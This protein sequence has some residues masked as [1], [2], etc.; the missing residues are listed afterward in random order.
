MVRGFPGSED[1]EGLVTTTD[2]DACSESPTRVAVITT[3]LLLATSGAVNSPLGEMVPALADQVTAVFGLP[4]IVAVNCSCSRDPTVVLPGESE[5]VI[6]RAELGA[7][8]PCVKPLQAI[9]VNVRP[10]NSVSAEARELDRRA[11]V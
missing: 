6:A 5:S 2:A 9:A 8:T 3:V 11:H 1:V 10:I 7:L 4:L